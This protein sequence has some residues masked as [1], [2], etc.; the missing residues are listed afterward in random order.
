M[1]FSAAI[2]RE[3]IVPE[4][5][6]PMDGVLI[7]WVHRSRDASVRAATLMAK[8]YKI[9]FPPALDSNHTR[10]LAIDM[11]IGDIVGKTVAKADGSTVVIRKHTDHES[12]VFDVG[13]SYGVLK[14]I[15]DK[16]HWS[17]DGH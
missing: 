4:N 2:A 10:R 15:S 16:P 1:H 6:P 14:L 9:V 12:D 13:A 3:T 17:A 11:R 5:V 8:A 7:E